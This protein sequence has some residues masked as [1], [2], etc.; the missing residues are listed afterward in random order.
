MEVLEVDTSYVSA[1]EVLAIIAWFTFIWGLCY[2][3]ICRAVRRYW[4]DD[5]YCSGRVIEVSLIVLAAVDTAALFFLWRADN[6]QRENWQA[7]IWIFLIFHFFARF[8]IEDAVHGYLA[9][10]IFSMVFIECGLITASVMMFVGTNPSTNTGPY[11]GL[12]APLFYGGFVIAAICVQTNCCRVCCPYSYYRDRTRDLS[13]WSNAKGSH[14]RVANQ[15]G[16]HRDSESG[17]DDE[18]EDEGGGGG[19]AV[20][21]SLTSPPT[22]RQAGGYHNPARF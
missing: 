4:N 9:W 18:D 3:P 22:H 12:F 7:A 5:G 13:A 8:P 14:A 19:V 17:D 11:L 20:M 16:R 1:A 2:K 21:K 10:G 6:G 15:T